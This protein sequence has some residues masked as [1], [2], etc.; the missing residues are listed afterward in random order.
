MT[1]EEKKAAIK[2]AMEKRGALAKNAN[3]DDKSDIA[4]QI[5]AEKDK[6]TG[7]KKQKVHGAQ[8]LY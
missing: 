3:K 2:A 4:S 8:P 1:A 6:R 7:G 5:K